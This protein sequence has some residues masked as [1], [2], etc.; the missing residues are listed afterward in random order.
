MGEACT[1]YAALLTH[2][3]SGVFSWRFLLEPLKHALKTKGMKKQVVRTEERENVSAAFYHLRRCTGI[4]VMDETTWKRQINSL[5][6]ISPFRIL[7]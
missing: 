4:T 5:R 7:L 6:M 2:E 1:W 3:T